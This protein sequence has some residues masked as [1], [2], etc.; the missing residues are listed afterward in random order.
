MEAGVGINWLLAGTIAAFVS[1]TAAAASAGCALPLRCGRRRGRW[2]Y[3]PIEICLTGSNNLKGGLKHRLQYPRSAFLPGVNMSISWRASLTC[4]WTDASGIG[5][6]I[7]AETRF[8]TASL[9][10]K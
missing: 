2:M 8:A 4:I 1:A 6:Q 7:S 5:R 3:P 9:L 10:S